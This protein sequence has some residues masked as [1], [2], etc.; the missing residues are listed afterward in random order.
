MPDRTPGELTFPRELTLD[1]DDPR[2]LL[3][4]ACSSRKRSDPGLLPA[5][6][7]YSGVNFAVL[8][9]ARREGRC[10]PNLDVLILSAKYGLLE[11]QTPIPDYDQVMTSARASV[12]KAETGR[13]LNTHMT[14]VVYSQIFINLGQAY[15]TA[16]STSSRLAA[17]QSTIVY[18][19]GGIGQRMAQM[20]QWLASMSEYAHIA[21]G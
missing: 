17:L 8:A 1:P 12:L 13:R 2:F 6:K 16:I 11:P 5:I 9:K 4:L 19:S 7:R 20:K 10:P 14:G 15:L 21:P 3:I 18:A